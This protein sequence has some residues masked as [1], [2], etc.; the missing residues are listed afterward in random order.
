MHTRPA[1]QTNPNSCYIQI[2]QTRTDNLNL[3]KH[4][5]TTISKTISGFCRF[6]IWTKWKIWFTFTG[7]GATIVG[8][9]RLNR[10]TGF[11]FLPQQQ[12]LPIKMSASWQI[13]R[14]LVRLKKLH[15]QERLDL[16]ESGSKIL[17]SPIHDKFNLKLVTNFETCEKFNPRGNP[18]RKPVPMRIS[19]GNVLPQY[20]KSQNLHKMH[21]IMKYQRNA[22]LG[23]FTLWHMRI[24]QTPENILT[25]EGLS[26]RLSL[27]LWIKSA[28]IMV[29]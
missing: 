7:R 4:G 3:H 15:S 11:D 21:H 10:K 22:H 25:L 27:L 29:S 13:W 20:K 18:Q 6:W 17:P 9:D 2:E 1:I 5:I 26:I 14:L 28:R 24:V 16:I 23:P 12:F 8:A 19:C